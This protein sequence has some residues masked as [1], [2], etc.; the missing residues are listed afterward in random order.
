MEA[1]Q[2]CSMCQKRTAHEVCHRCETSLMCSHCLTEFRISCF[3]CQ[4]EIYFSTK[5]FDI[6]R[7]HVGE[8]RLYTLNNDLRRKRI[9][10]CTVC[11]SFSNSRIPSDPYFFE[12][13]VNPYF[14]L[15]WVFDE[16]RA[17]YMCPPDHDACD[18]CDWRKQPHC[19]CPQCYNRSKFCS[20]EATFA[21]IVRRTKKNRFFR[22]II[23]GDSTNSITPPNDAQPRKVART[24]CY[25]CE[26]VFYEAFCPEPTCPICGA[27]QRVRENAETPG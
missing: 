22:K 7:R 14:I 16:E 24:A 5:R 25:A 9:D 13:S 20:S 10:G 17:Y 26:A 19:M 15:G 2:I 27:D 6:E 1:E 8:V 4:D 23:G 12:K 11:D 3:A 18:V 21:G